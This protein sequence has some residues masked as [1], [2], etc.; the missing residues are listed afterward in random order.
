MIF[1]KLIINLWYLLVLTENWHN[2]GPK[3]PQLY[4]KAMTMRAMV[5]VEVDDSK[6][7]SNKSEI[8]K[9]W[10]STQK[11]SV[12]RSKRVR[13]KINFSF[14]LYLTFECLY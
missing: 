11:G 10:S 13:H 2:F 8:D 9:L 7:S 1:P 5:D 14:H 3:S 12:K 6:L 4:I